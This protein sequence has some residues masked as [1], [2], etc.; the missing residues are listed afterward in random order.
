MRSCSTPI[1]SILLLRL[2]DHTFATTLLRLVALTQKCSIQSA[3]KEALLA[4]KTL[5]RCIRDLSL[6]NIYLNLILSLG[7]L[8]ILDIRGLS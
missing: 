6:R 5:T 2:L 4:H 1:S 8:A 3:L 7:F